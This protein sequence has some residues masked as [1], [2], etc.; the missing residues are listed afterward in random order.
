MTEW[1]SEWVILFKYKLT[2]S[3]VR[4]QCILCNNGF[5]VIFLRHLISL[6]LFL[7]LRFR[8]FLRFSSTFSLSSLNWV[9]RH[10][11]WI[12]WKSLILYWMWCDD[13]IACYS[14]IFVFCSKRKRK[15]NS[16]RT[17]KSSCRLLCYAHVR[18]QQCNKGCTIENICDYKNWMTFRAENEIDWNLY[19][20]SIYKCIVLYSLHTHV[21]LFESTDRHTNKSDT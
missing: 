6:L 20:Q 14:P 9:F 12:N 5:V 19:E 16:K 4:V 15:K 10:N 7:H 11:S 8:L 17:V 3:N 1:V 2:S 13:A 21:L 18:V